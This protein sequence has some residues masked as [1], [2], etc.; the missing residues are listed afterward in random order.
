MENIPIIGRTRV[1]ELVAIG[2]AVLCLM[3]K[4]TKWNCIG[5]SFWFLRRFQIRSDFRSPLSLSLSLGKVLEKVFAAIK[6]FLCFFCECEREATLS[7]APSRSAEV[8]R[9]IVIVCCCCCFCCSF[10]STSPIFVVSAD[11]WKMG[12]W[13]LF[14]FCLMLMARRNNNNN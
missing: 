8:S 1:H 14:S 11:L 3:I 9:G 10:C 12:E 13:G 5:V 2:C 6:L 4:L 7:Y